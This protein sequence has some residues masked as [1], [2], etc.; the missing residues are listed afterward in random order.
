M[1]IPVE[2]EIEVE[3]YRDH[4]GATEAAKSATGDEHDHV[5]FVHVNENGLVTKGWTSKAADGPTSTS[6]ARTR[7]PRSPCWSPAAG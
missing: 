2:V 4:Y 5:Y 6:S 3:T 7:S 1:V